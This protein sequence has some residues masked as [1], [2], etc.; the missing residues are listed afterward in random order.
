MQIKL[1]WAV[2]AGSTV[3]GIVLFS[4]LFELKPIFATVDLSK[5]YDGIILWNSGVK[6]FQDFQ[7]CV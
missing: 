1:K 5:F 3:F 4:D 6:Q 2:S 7:V